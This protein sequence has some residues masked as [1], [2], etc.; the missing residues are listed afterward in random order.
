MSPVRRPSPA[1]APVA[2]A[3]GCLALLAVRLPGPLD[4]PGHRILWAVAPVLLALATAALIGWSAWRVAG[5]RAGLLSGTLV[6]ASGPVVLLTLLA[7]AFRGT[8]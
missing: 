3:L 4:V 6:L 1:W 8:T 5:S 2:A 7:P